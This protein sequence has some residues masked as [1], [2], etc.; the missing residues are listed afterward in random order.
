MLLQ[1]DEHNIVFSIELLSLTT[2]A[3]TA[4]LLAELLKKNESKNREYVLQKSDSHEIEI[5]EQKC[6]IRLSHD[7]IFRRRDKPEKLGFRCEFIE[8]TLLAEGSFGKVYLTTTLP[9]NE[10]FFLEKRRKN[11]QK[12][13]IVKVLSGEL[14]FTKKEAELMESLPHLHSK[15]MIVNQTGNK[16]YIVMQKLP[17]QDLSEVLKSLNSSIDQSIE[18]FFALLRALKEQV[19]DKGLVHRDIKPENIMVELKPNLAPPTVNMIDYGCSIRIGGK[20]DVRFYGNSRYSSPEALRFETHTQ[21]SDIF[22]LGKIIYQLFSGGFQYKID[23]DGKKAD[24][25]FKKCT[26]EPLDKEA[27]EWISHY[28][29]GPND[30][31]GNETN[32][33]INHRKKLQSLINGMLANDPDSRPNLNEL[34]TELQIIQK[35]KQKKDKQ[36]V[37][38]RQ[39]VPKGI[40]SLFTSSLSSAASKISLTSEGTQRSFFKC[41]NSRF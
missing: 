15:R 14:A 8:D 41:N 17:G 35:E 34:M 2:D 19:H 25:W 27:S 36:W 23:I 29:I 24:E 21:A 5:E 16:S 39:C 1:T 28:G 7:L 4:F 13:R 38:L 20:S 33:N 3:F 30:N 10:K 37:F 6:F 26:E 18:I 40:L 11:K 31:F 32:I 9:I 22:S 12:K